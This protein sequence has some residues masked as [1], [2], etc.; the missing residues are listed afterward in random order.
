MKKKVMMNDQNFFRHFNTYKT[1]GGKTTTCSDKIDT[2]IKS[3]ITVVRFYQ[4]C[5]PAQPDTFSNIN[6]KHI[7]NLFTNQVEISSTA[8]RTNTVE[9]KNVGDKMEKIE[10]VEFAGSS[11]ECALLQLLEL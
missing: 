6:N 3:K 2:I 11:S 9:E 5:S 8:Y 7:E 1:V 4:I 10:K